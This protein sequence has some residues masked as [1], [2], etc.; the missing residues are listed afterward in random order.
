MR[1]SEAESSSRGWRDKARGGG[2]GYRTLIAYRLG[3]FAVFLFGCARKDRENIAA[4]ELEI[5]KTIAAPW[6]G[7]ARKIAEDANAG[8]LIEVTDDDVES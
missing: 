7:D 2:G 8:I 5:L 1:T 6:F 4:E 3:D